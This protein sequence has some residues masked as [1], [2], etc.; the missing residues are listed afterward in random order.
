MNVEQNNKG[1]TLL[2]GRIE[3]A[4]IRS[5][6]HLVHHPSSSAVSDVLTSV[7]VSRLFFQCKYPYPLFLSDNLISGWRYNPKT[8]FVSSCS[9][10]VRE[11]LVT[12]R[13]LLRTQCCT[14]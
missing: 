10:R 13:F 14:F 5:N 12:S 9:P 6:V 8:E 2:N 11:V 4:R 7:T 3:E 1:R